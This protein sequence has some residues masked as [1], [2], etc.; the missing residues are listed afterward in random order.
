MVYVWL[1]RMLLR[2]VVD[3]TSPATRS[4][5]FPA[6]HRRY[7]WIPTWLD[8]AVQLRETEYDVSPVIRRSPGGVG[9]E[10]LGVGVGVGFGGLFGAATADCPTANR[11]ASDA[12]RTK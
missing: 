6:Q 11:N 10:V 4:L 12:T 5:L 2:K 7:A 1:G 8:E 3:R 9:P